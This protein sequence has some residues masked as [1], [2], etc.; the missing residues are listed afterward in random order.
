M[1][2]LRSAVEELVAVDPDELDDVA[3]SALL[4]EVSR[5]RD[6]L[7][8]VCH[9][10]IAAQDRRTAWKA[11]GAHS[12]KQWLAENCRLSLGQASR[13][14]ETARRLAALP[15]TAQAVADGTIGMGQA[16]V[17][18]A[19]VRDLPGEAAEGLDQL[20]VESPE[21]DAGQLRSAVDEYAHRVRPASLAAREAR[22]WRAR[23]LTV[24]RTGDGAVAIDGRLDPVS[25]EAVLTALAPL[26]A[27]A[28]AGDTRTPEQRRADALVSL[29]K[30]ALDGGGLPEVGGVRPHVTVV[31]P[32]ETLQGKPG[33]P[34]AVLD[35]YGAIS[36]EAARLLACDSGVTRVITMGPSQPIDVGRET[37]VVTVAQRR[38]LAV[39]DGGCI[40]CRAPVAWCQAHH[41]VFWVDLGPTDL[42]NLVLVCWRCH[43]NIHHQGWQPIRGPNGRWRLERPRGYG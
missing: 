41:V 10:L 37:R 6:R 33:A 13:Q 28:D 40:G 2:E 34:P 43:R 24:S 3:L 9:R 5:Q 8:G 14:A 11:D 42:D 18:A 12:Q 19:A 20:V 26:A 17:A 35:R 27:P 21:V 4:V 36:G 38:G 39:R 32:L 7:D 31:V 29:C 1:G 25:G 22:A 16:Q 23:R 15:Q 30:R